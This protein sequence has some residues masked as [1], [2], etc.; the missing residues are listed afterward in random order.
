[1]K[2]RL[3]AYGLLAVVAAAA[4]LLCYWATQATHRTEVTVYSLP[5]DAGSVLAGAAFRPINAR[6][7]EELA[8]RPYRS[9]A[10]LVITGIAQP[11]RTFCIQLKKQLPSG[12]ACQLYYALPGEAL[13]ERN[14]FDTLLDIDS[15]RI[16]FVLPQAA[17][18]ETY[19]LD[20][21][22]A[23]DIEDILVSEAPAA[24][25]VALYAQ[26]KAAG[27]VSAPW[28]QMALG[29][30]LLFGVG[31]AFVGEKPKK[32]AAAQPESEPSGRGGN[33]L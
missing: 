18:Y 28:G 32:T 22:A 21:D 12:T 29:F 1:M 30:A 16:F 3:C 5:E 10:Q 27:H 31:A 24:A 20:I 25:T 13:A 14:S 17:V 7:S 26:E 19:R 6:L 33:I 23:Y 2:K 11:T 15:D 9:D 8:F 4:V